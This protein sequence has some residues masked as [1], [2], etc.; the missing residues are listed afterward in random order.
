MKFQR[1]VS[2]AVF[3]LALG[4]LASWAAPASAA[5]AE[6]CG[7]SAC[8]T[9]DCYWSSE[10]GAGK[11]CD[12]ASGCTKSGKLDGTCTTS[13]GVV[14]ANPADVASSL[15]SWFDAYIATAGAG[16]D[17]LPDAYFVSQ[18]LQANLSDQA[19][20]LVRDEVINA[21]DVL[22]GFDVTL[23]RGNC[24]EQDPRCLGQ[25]RIPVEP[26]G[27]DLLEAAKQALVS[28]VVSGDLSKVDDA[29]DAYWNN[30][31]FEPHHT[32]RCYAHGHA[33]FSVSPLQCQKDELRRIATLLISSTRVRV[34][35]Q[36]PRIR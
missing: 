1:I 30:S 10:C 8:P 17:G 13:S 3:F 34:T 28:A 20:R 18:A 12:Y 5:I 11:K 36:A 24:F 7:I 29:L 14:I 15:S 32:G 26:E 33:G 35:S 6:R 4:I 16:K 22:L 21:L 31:T 25:Y 2:L 27:I 23:P 9:C 19:R